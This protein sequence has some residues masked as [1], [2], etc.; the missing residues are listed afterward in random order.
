MFYCI[1]LFQGLKIDD[2]QRQIL[3]HYLNYPL[4]VKV[5]QKLGDSIIINM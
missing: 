3:L 2:K 4:E 1:T 5:Q